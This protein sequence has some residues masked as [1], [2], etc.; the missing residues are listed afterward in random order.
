MVN[1]IPISR[2]ILK[3]VARDLIKRSAAGDSTL[4]LELLLQSS[5]LD[6]RLTFTRASSATDIINGVLTSF[7]SGAARISTANG[8]LM[9]ESRTN[10][11]WNSSIT[12]GNNVTVT[13][14]QTDPFGGTNAF[15][16]TE[17]TS[18]TSHVMVAN[19]NLPTGST[20]YSIS[21]F[22]KPGTCNRVQLASSNAITTTSEYMNFYLSGSGSITGTGG[23]MTNGFIQALS[24]GWYRIGCTY[25]TVAS[26]SSANTIFVIFLSTGS[27]TKLPAFTGTSRTITVYGI[28]TE[29]GSF[30]TS[31]IPTTT[32]NVTRAADSCT[33]STGAWFNAT[34]GTLWAQSGPMADGGTTFPRI[35]SLHDGTSN[36][37]L[38]IG[39]D[40]AANNVVLV[41]TASAV[42]QTTMTI[43]TPYQG[44]TVIKS[45]YAY[46]SNDSNGAAD[47]VAATTD[48]AC[49]VPTVTTLDIGNLSPAG[50]RLLNG[51]VR[52]VRYYNVRKTNT[53]LQALTT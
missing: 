39:L 17:D 48:T 14:S 25:T 34:E 23:N 12:V 45:A 35:V 19:A 5:T 16:V 30:P 8:L 22:V 4:T 2:D 3:P 7:S 49:A 11:S 37:F 52:G 47:G 18:N 31:Y 42:S 46:K 6:P 26:P 27:E 50:N 24:G 10:I 53:E 36:N 44:A 15:L 33:M 51:Y 13:G 20:K 32:A 9:E 38:S 41:G 43:K 29:Q 40:D 1:L 28:Q 21:A